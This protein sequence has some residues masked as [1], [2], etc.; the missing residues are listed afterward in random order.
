MDITCTSSSARPPPLLRFLVE[1]I[2]TDINTNVST[3]L[4]DPTGLYTSVSTLHS[5]KREWGNKNMSCQQ[6]PEMIGLYHEMLLSNI[7]TMVSFNQTGT[8][9]VIRW[10][11]MNISK[12]CLS[13]CIDLLSHFDDKRTECSSV[14]VILTDTYGMIHVLGLII[15]DPPSRLDLVIDQGKLS[16]VITAICTSMFA[17]PACDIK[18]ESTIEHFQ[19]T[20]IE[21]RTFKEATE[22]IISFNATNEDYGKQIRCSTECQYFKNA[23]VNATNVIFAKKPTVVVYSIPVL[24]VPPNTTIVLICAANAYPVG[25]ITWTMEKSSNSISPQTK[26]CSKCSNASTCAYEM[27]TSDDEQ[28]YSCYAKNVHGSDEGSIIVVHEHNYKEDLTGKASGILGVTIGVSGG[29][30]FLFIVIV[31]MCLRLRR[32]QGMT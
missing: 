4:E 22:S 20:S 23:L 26:T 17:N 8:G 15:L 13:K 32:N 16:K 5:F 21:N 1:D 9:D 31:V 29:I 28:V 7:S 11:T 2:E 12:I 18:W 10:M 24:P 3:M 27:I 30:A 6:F 25:N 19:Y 14:C